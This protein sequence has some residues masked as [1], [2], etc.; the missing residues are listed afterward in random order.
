M[1]ISFA[2]LLKQ[3]SRSFWRKAIEHFQLKMARFRFKSVSKPF[4]FNI[5]NAKNWFPSF[6]NSKQ[7]FLTSELM[8]IY[9]TNVTTNLMTHRVKRFP[10]YLKLKVFKNNTLLVTF[11]E[12][13]P[14]DIS[15]AIV[16]AILKKDI[17]IHINEDAVKRWIVFC[18]F[19]LVGKCL[20]VFIRQ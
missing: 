14:N 16:F 2:L 7:E 4:S 10:Q 8:K 18:A 12:N 15:N 19:L 9:A 17:E 20:H 6:A 3:S 5:S 1:R 11:I 13:V